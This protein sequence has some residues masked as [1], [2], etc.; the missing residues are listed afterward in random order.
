M[1][2]LHLNALSKSIVPLLQEGERDAGPCL[3]ES[4]T[5]S[6]KWRVS[7]VIEFVEGKYTALKSERGPNWV[8]AED[9]CL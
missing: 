8:A 9:C 4:K 6:L 1:R 5:E 2:C 7:K 3:V